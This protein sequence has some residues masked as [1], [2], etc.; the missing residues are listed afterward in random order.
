MTKGTVAAI[1]HKYLGSGG[2][3]EGQGHGKN[4]P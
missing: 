3:A 1:E 2:G 4:F